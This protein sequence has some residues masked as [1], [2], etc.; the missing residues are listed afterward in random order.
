MGRPLLFP[1]LGQGGPPLHFRPKGRNEGAGFRTLFRPK[2][3]QEG[4]SPA[5]HTSVETNAMTQPNPFFMS[6]YGK[7]GPL[8]RGSFLLA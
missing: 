2:V 5:G 1:G 8:V 7:A 3:G 6:V 4:N